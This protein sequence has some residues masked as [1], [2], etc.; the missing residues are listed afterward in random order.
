MT[1]DDLLA[2]IV[3]T[4]VSIG[5]SYYMAFNQ[6]SKKIDSI[7]SNEFLGILTQDQ[8]EALV[9]IYIQMIRKALQWEI[10]DYC[11]FHLEKLTADPSEESVRARLNHVITARYFRARQ[12]VSLEFAP[13]KISKTLSFMK[14]LKSADRKDVPSTS[15]ET[16]KAVSAYIVA[17]PTN[18]ESARNALKHLLSTKMATLN[19]EGLDLMLKAIMKWYELN[20][21]LIVANNSGPQ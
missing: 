13:F 8:A 3:V 9:H 14:F 7:I 19:L 2:S 10:D 20:P 5:A 17:A 16:V 18:K 1:S 15:E 4:V 12:I 6:I 21:G 11:D